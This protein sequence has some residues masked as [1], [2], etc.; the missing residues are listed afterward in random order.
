V[1]NNPVIT[2][3]LPTYKR[4]KLLKK[5]LQSILN[6]T[7][8]H[9]KICVYDDASDDETGKVVAEM[10]KKDLRIFYYCH[11]QN[12]G[13]VANIRHAWTQVDT[14][15]FVHLAD[16]DIFLPDHFK[17]ALDGFRR[18]PEAIFSANQA[19]SMNHRR[20][21]HKVTLSGNCRE[22][23]YE[24]PEGLMF[25]L[26]ND[27]SILQGAIYKS[28]V[29]ER[30]GGYDPE[31]GPISDWDYIFRIAAQFPYVVNKT[32]GIIFYINETGF[33][34]SARSQ[35]FWPQWLRMFKKVVGNSNLGSETKL[36]V[37][38]HLKSRLKSMLFSQGKD[39]ILCENYTD[40]K[41]SAQVLKEFFKSPRHC[42]KL[43]LLAFSCKWFP[44]Y[45]WFV[46]YYQ[47]LRSRKKLLEAKGR[48][49]EYQKYTS[50][51]QD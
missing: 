34:G 28:E 41:K 50:Y 13:L 23:L 9:F 1:D 25:L 20:Q 5:A 36:E 42:L 3:I 15:Y 29:R 39:A 16:D 45:R 21:I 30:V 6:Q 26:K 38:K 32:P 2:V 10:S 44:P 27:P 18:Y 40:A 22:G 7:Y 17:N 48:H 49:Y 12:L 24:P 43:R 31:M 47:N 8:P 4:P 11:E 33:S 46:K 14:P 51:L 35:F 37:E 19:I